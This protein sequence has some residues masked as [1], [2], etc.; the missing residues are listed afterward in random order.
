MSS[1]F[2]IVVVVV[3]MQKITK[4]IFKITDDKKFNHILIKYSLK[5]TF[6]MENLKIRL[7][8]IHV[9]ANNILRIRKLV[10]YYKYS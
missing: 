6:I 9:L 10:N 7:F 2:P 5:R 3:I 1:N 4:L 8:S